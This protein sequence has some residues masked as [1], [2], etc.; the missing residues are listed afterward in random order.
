MGTKNTPP[1]LST[2]NSGAVPTTVT[3]LI[4]KH[5]AFNQMITVIPETQQVVGDISEN[6]RSLLATKSVNDLIAEHALIKVGKKKV[7]VPVETKTNE[8]H[9]PKD[10]AEKET[11]ESEQVENPEKK[12]RVD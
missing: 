9:K 6:L 5:L 8:A 1:E 7:P 10:D 11:T 4:Y 2:D 3:A 12:P